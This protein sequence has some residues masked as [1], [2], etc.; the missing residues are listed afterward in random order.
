MLGGTRPTFEL[1]T[2]PVAST[3]VLAMQRLRQVKRR[4][5]IVTF[6][7]V[8]LALIAAIALLIRLMR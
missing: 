7:I 1:G 6:T 3:E 5:P 8:G 2:A 4:G